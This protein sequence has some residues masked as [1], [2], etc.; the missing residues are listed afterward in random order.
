MGL[1]IKVQN[2]KKST[3]TGKSYVRND[4]NW[5]LDD[6][7]RKNFNRTLDKEA[8]GSSTGARP[9]E[10]GRCK[11]SRWLL[12]QGSAAR[13]TPTKRNIVGPD[14]PVSSFVHTITLQTRRRHTTNTSSSSDCPPHTTPSVSS[15]RLVSSLLAL[16]IAPSTPSSDV[17]LPPPLC[18]LP[19]LL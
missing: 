13:R 14:V 16:R 8:R 17:L 9:Q 2:D 3:V 12:H 19:L 1:F 11:G 10:R 7:I 6:V 4:L 15:S 5:T 18:P